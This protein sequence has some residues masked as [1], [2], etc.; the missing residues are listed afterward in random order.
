VKYKSSIALCAALL[1]GAACSAI[2]KLITI[3]Q[4]PPFATISMDAETSGVGFVTSPGAFFYR[5]VD[6]TNVDIT[7]VGTVQNTCGLRTVNS[8]PGATPVDTLPTAASPLG[9]GPFVTLRLSGLVDSLLP[10]SAQ[11]V[12]YRLPPSTTRPFTPGDTATFSFAG[13]ASGF[14]AATVTLPTAE[15]FTLTPVVFAQSGQDM[16]VTWTPPVSPGSV[17]N[18]TITYSIGPFSSQ[19]FCQFVDDGQAVVPAGYF[20]AFPNPVPGHFVD[21]VEAIRM[22]T[23]LVQLPG[24]GAIANAISVFAVPTPTSP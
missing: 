3:E 17:M 22:R 16:P 9:A 6:N 4:S 1:V 7:T 8:A 10:P 20:T 23:T 14:P 12:G 19:I 21:G 15:A 2:D 11:S 13:D 18:F 24:S 5:A